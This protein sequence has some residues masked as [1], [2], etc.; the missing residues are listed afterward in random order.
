M[1][2][3]GD[4]S[5]IYNDL[6]TKWLQVLNVAGREEVENIFNDRQKAY[7]Y[8]YPEIMTITK[9]KESANRIAIMLIDNFPEIMRTASLTLGLRKV[10]V[11]D[12]ENGEYVV[13]TKDRSK[14]L[15]R[16]KT[17]KDAINQ[18][19]AIELNKKAWDNGGQK[20]EDYHPGSNTGPV[21]HKTPRA[22]SD[23]SRGDQR[24]SN[25]FTPSLI[26]RDFEEEHSGV[27]DR[28]S[29]ADAASSGGGSQSHS[30]DPGKTDNIY[31]EPSNW[32]RPF[33]NMPIPPNRY[34]QDF[35]TGFDTEYTQRQYGKLN[36]HRIPKLSTFDKATIQ[37]KDIPKQVIDFIQKTQKDIDSSVLDKAHD[38][39]GW[40][41]DGK[42]QNFHITILFGVADNTEKIISEIF[43]KHKPINDISIDKIEYFDNANDKN[44]EQ[45]VAVL[46]CKSAKLNKLHKEL[47]KNI[48]N[49][50]KSGEYVA[51]ITIAY[52]KDKER[53]QIENIPNITWAINNIEIS[54]STGAIKKI[55]EN[56]NPDGLDNV[57]AWC[58][59]TYDPDTGEILRPLSDEEYDQVISHGICNSCRQIQLEQLRNSRTRR[60]NSMY[61]PPDDP[62]DKYNQMWWRQIRK[63]LENPTTTEKVLWQLVVEHNQSPDILAFAL[64][65]PNMQNTSYIQRIQQWLDTIDASTI[66]QFENEQA[67]K[68]NIEKTEEDHRES[69]NQLSLT[70][71]EASLLE[72]HSADD[73]WDMA[74]NGEPLAQSLIQKGVVASKSQVQKLAV[75]MWMPII[76]DTNYPRQIRQFIKK[77]KNA[78][79][80]ED[81]GKILFKH[82]QVREFLKD[83]PIEYKK[84]VKHVRFS[85]ILDAV[86]DTLDPA[87][88]QIG[89]K[90]IPMLKPDIKI[91]IVSRFFSYIDRF[92]G[93]ISP[94]TWVKNM[95]YCGS[96]ATYRYN[97]KSDIDIH[98][99]V[100]WHDMVTANPDKKHEDMDKV[101]REL[102]DTFW[103][104]L[105]N[106]KLPG[107]KHPMQ[108]YVI[109]PGEEHKLTE[110][111]EEIFDIGHEVW[112][113][114]PEKIVEDPKK[115]LELA[116]ADASKVI[117]RLDQYLSDTRKGLVDYALLTE[118][119]TEDNVKNIYKQLTNTIAE[120]DKNLHQLKKE[121]NELK[122]NRQDAFTEQS[123]NNNFSLDNVIFKIV[124]RYKYMDVLRKI[125]RITDDM[126]LSV[127]DI[128]DIADTLGLAELFE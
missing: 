117:R 16:H 121:Y 28:G 60:A 7:E 49:T 84:R 116:A 1:I 109:K 81:A 123:T 31:P 106:V 90:G 114:P 48:P 36:L 96:T 42:Q 128:P 72:N 93:Y 45:T 14:E 98:V 89:P 88:W 102:H 17:K 77:I 33:K 4:E 105:N 111:K 67:Q 50:H 52:L 40:I 107:T 46:K 62:D 113:V 91:E 92:G 110:Q 47:A 126:E 18:L 119:V 79:N 83:R 6:V 74:R 70:P 66:E 95:F 39:K 11:I 71:Q 27:S 2:K 65:H 37:T 58:R 38:E 80:I 57:C 32:L 8:V 44:D 22:L 85:N 68:E 25:Y 94:E 122:A 43:D 104:T 75:N 23:L 120:I 3:S 108:Y 10:A 13:K 51:H 24:G 56:I 29:N 20:S 15:G 100:D 82:K 9:N 76:E 125:K 124:E 127:D 99:I 118:L 34:N 112:L 59:S 41:K 115:V 53:L 61:I 78:S 73:I 21:P 86:R 101:W 30:G 26:E 97:D 12:N 54:K 103:W 55:A 69:N 87:I 35:N 19:Q 5:S 63:T 64:N